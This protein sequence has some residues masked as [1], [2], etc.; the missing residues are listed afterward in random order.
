MHLNTGVCMEAFASGAVDLHKRLL[1]KVVHVGVKESPWQ[2]GRVQMSVQGC[3]LQC[4]GACK[5]GRGVHL[6]VGG[7]ALHVSVRALRC[8]QGQQGVHGGVLHVGVQLCTHLRVREHAR[9]WGGVQGWGCSHLCTN[10]ACG[11]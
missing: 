11:E 7:D 3:R 1:H 9:H 8:V 2:G 5:S 4:T 6:H 10:G